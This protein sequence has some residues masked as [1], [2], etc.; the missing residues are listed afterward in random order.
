M[1]NV[2][3][4]MEMKY[5]MLAGHTDP[6]AGIGFSECPKWAE[7]VFEPQQHGWTKSEKIEMFRWTVFF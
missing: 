3:W 7:C 5:E 2:G 1:W 6:Q 4:A